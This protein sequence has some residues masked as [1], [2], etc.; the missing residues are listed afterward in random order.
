[1]TEIHHIVV[2]ERVAG[3]AP[4]ICQRK[5]LHIEV[6]MESGVGHWGTCLETGKELYCAEDDIESLLQM[7]TEAATCKHS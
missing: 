4:D 3:C 6:Y 2:L 1:M 7:F 5:V